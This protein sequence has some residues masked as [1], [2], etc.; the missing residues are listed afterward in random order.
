M[1]S[2]SKE[3]LLLQSFPPRLLLSSPSCICA[4]LWRLCKESHILQLFLWARSSS[5]GTLASSPFKSD[6][7][8]LQRAFNLFRAR[9]CSLCLVLHYIVS[10]T[11]CR[12]LFSSFQL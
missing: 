9:C 5:R 3:S 1:L 7:R 12:L 4:L 8:R 2:V 6:A 10:H 11:R